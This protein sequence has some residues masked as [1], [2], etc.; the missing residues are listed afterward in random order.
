MFDAYFGCLEVCVS[1]CVSVPVSV[2]VCVCLPRVFN[3][4][5]NIT[6][7]LYTTWTNH[8]DL[9]PCGTAIDCCSLSLIDDSVIPPT[10]TGLCN[11]TNAHENSSRIIWLKKIGIEILPKQMNKFWL[12]K[13]RIKKYPIQIHWSNWVAK[14]SSCCLCS[15][16]AS[17][18]LM[19]IFRWL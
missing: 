4:V 11:P 18:S 2:C 19:N 9:Y 17:H 1:E 6:P 16:E 5:A 8:T 14:N 12:Q 3:N 7:C 15:N 10:M 13:F